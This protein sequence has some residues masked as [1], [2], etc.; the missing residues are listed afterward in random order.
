[1]K[2]RPVKITDEATLIANLKKQIQLHNGE[3]FSDR[4]FGKILNHLEGGSIFDRAERLRDKFR[5]DRD[6][7]SRI[8]IEFLNI[9]DWC[10]NQ[11]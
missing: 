7:G 6:D 3:T 11:Y 10:Q 9:R 8:W 4:E 2:Y 5:L 1:M